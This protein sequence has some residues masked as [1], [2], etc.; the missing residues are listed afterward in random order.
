MVLE[1][2]LGILKY[3]M[4]FP[5]EKLLATDF[6]FLRQNTWQKSLKRE[7]S[8]QFLGFEKYSPSW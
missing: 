2:S 1:A 6:V 4:E 8:F 7:R 3:P 5:L